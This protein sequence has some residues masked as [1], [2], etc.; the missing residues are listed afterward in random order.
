[1]AKRFG[2]TVAVVMGRIAS[3]LGPG[4][5]RSIARF[6]RRVTNPIQRLWAPY[7]PYYA[8]IEHTG[9]KSGKQYQTPVMAF[10]ERGKLAVMLNYGA[11]SDWVRNIKAAGSAGVVHRG[12]RYRLSDPQVV[13]TDSPDLPSAIQ[14]A[15]AGAGSALYG[16]LVRT[17]G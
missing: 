4:R 15:G 16:T 17:G 14:A 7:L 12:N 6:N 8:V 3:L 5:M 13:P 11:E 1:M 2:S 9:R 10:V